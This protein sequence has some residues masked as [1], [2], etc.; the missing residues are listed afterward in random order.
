MEKGIQDWLI[1]IVELRCELE[2]NALMFICKELSLRNFEKRFVIKVEIVLTKLISKQLLEITI[3]STDDSF[4]KRVSFE[5]LVV[6]CLLDLAWY[7]V[8]TPRNNLLANVCW[9]HDELT[10]TILDRLIY[11]RLDV[12]FLV[13]LEATFD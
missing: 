8:K 1:H 5:F 6:L 7:D 4:N 10:N 11:L 13:L 3:E 9:M 12:H 2:S